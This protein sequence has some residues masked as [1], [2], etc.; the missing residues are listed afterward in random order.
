[1]DKTISIAD[2]WELPPLRSLYDFLLE[3][4]RF[5]LPN[6]RDL[7]KWGNRVANNLVYYQTNYLYMCIAIILVV[8]SVHP[9]KMIVG[10]T[11][12]MAIWGECIYLF[13][14]KESLLKFKRTYPQ[15]GVILTIICGSFVIYTINSVL[16]VLFGILL[17][18]CVIFIH[19][20]LRLRNVKNKLANKI[21][22]MGLKRTPMGVILNYFGMKEEFFT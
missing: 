20:S 14:E 19:A 7:E 18:F 11:A 5:Q 2:G 12:A 1:M 22:G 4:S 21:E 13:S 15:V 10:I 16:F 3:S 8:A 9:V 6:F 17:S